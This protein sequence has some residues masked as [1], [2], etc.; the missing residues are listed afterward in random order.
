MTKEK[1]IVIL[2]GFMGFAIGVCCMM[3]V[4]LDKEIRLMKKHQIE[5]ENIIEEVYKYE[6]EYIND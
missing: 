6:G 5:L 2:S 3:F 4:N 1:E